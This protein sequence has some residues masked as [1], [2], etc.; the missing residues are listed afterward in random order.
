MARGGVLGLAHRAPHGWLRGAVHG[1]PAPQRPAGRP[2]NTSARPT[3]PR[4]GFPERPRNPTSRESTSPPTAGT[5]SRRRARPRRGLPRWPSSRRG[6]DHRAVTAALRAATLARTWPLSAR[7][8]IAFRSCRRPGSCRCAGGLPG[9]DLAALRLALE[10][11]PRHSPSASPVCTRHSAG[12]HG[13]VAIRHRCVLHQGKERVDDL[14]LA[15]GAF[16]PQSLAGRGQREVSPVGSGRVCPCEAPGTRGWGSSG[17]HVR[18]SPCSHR[19]R[20][21]TREERSAH[22]QSRPRVRP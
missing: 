12:R 9:A 3:D 6:R 8:G 5:S 4:E 10:P 20:V 13:P 22:G 21:R 18:W 15:A 16:V 14:K 19:G 17:C 11:H 2:T 1:R 7:C